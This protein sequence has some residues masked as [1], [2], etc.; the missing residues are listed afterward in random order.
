MLYA[1]FRALFVSER[2]QIAIAIFLATS[3]SEMGTN[4]INTVI[5]G[6]TLKLDTENY[7]FSPTA[8]DA[9]T[10]AMLSEVEF[11]AEDK[12]LDLGCGYGIVGLTAAGIIGGSRV[13]MCDIS[14]DAIRLSKAN[15][16]LNGMDISEIKQ[17]DGLRS[18]EQSDFTLILSN[19]PYHTDF[20]VAKHFIEEG[21]KRLVVG[22][23]MVMVT[24]RL[25]WYKEKLT[26]VFGGVRIVEKD[27]YY[28]FISEKRNERI[29]RKTDNKPAISK[30]LARKMERRGKKWTRS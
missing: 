4:M 12:I 15:A 27:G 14:E 10:L 20:S 5:K 6:V 19:P 25:E 30:K 16:L 23:R 9:G 22:G 28:V 3:R 18:I 21:F 26:S 7:Y 8:P 2:K 17:S 1:L 24:K 29:K 11:C 13:V